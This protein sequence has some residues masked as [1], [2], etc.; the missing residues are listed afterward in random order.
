AIKFT[1]AGGHITLRAV[2]GEDGGK[3]AVIVQIEDDGRGISA[4]DQKRIFDRFVQLKHSEKMDIRGTGLGLSICRAFV[5]LHKGRLW[6]ES[7]PPGK[8]QGSLFSFSLP[9]YDK[10]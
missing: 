2:E 3:K 8:N 1:P 10:S 7:P 6:V 5:D 4:E 9:A